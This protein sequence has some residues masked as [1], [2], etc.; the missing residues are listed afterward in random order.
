MCSF[1]NSTCS[2]YPVDFHQIAYKLFRNLVQGKLKIN[3]NKQ[4][5]TGDYISSLECVAIWSDN[6]R[7]Y[8]WQN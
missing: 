5:N 6:R 8:C 1:L 2:P 7:V 3:K 4:T